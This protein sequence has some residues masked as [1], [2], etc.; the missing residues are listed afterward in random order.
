[1]IKQKITQ[2]QIQAMKQKDQDKVTTLRY[3][4]AQLKNKEIDKK[5]GLSD[6]EELTILRKIAKELRES[7]EAFRKGKRE[8]LVVQYDKQLVLVS[9]YLPKEISDEELKNEIEKIMQDN[10]ELY[11]KNPKAII[12]ISMKQLKNKADPSRILKLVQTNELTNN[13]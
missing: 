11:G 3:I 5:S 10:K 2:D 7:I 9:S 8:D 6:E 12:G 13:E 4:L 1:M